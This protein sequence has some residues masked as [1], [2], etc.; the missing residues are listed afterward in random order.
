MKATHSR[1]LRSR[2][3]FT[4]A[5]ILVVLAIVAVLAAVL[6]PAVLGQLRKG[7]VSRIA[8]DLDA[9]RVGIETFVADVHRYPSQ[10]AHLTTAITSGGTDINGD[11][12]PPGLAARWKGPYLNKVLDGDTLITGFSGALQNTLLKE[13]NT[14]SVYY[15]TVQVSGIAAADFDDIDE[16]VDG[17][18]NS[19]TGQLRYATSLIKYLAV[20][21]N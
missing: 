18:A 1:A 14:N 21:I 7:D 9:A 4:L 20:P 13:L 10:L 2:H 15:V 8:T 16:I 3:G 12:Y 6:V 19:S 11:T 5:E 17:T